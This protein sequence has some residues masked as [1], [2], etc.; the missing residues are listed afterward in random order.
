[1][2]A[3]FL[4]TPYPFDRVTLG[5]YLY[6]MVTKGDTRIVEAMLQ[7]GADPNITGESE[8]GVSLLRRAATNGHTDITG[9]LLAHG[10]NHRRSGLD[11]ISPL[12][13]A[14]A[15]GHTEIVTQLLAAGANPNQCD[16][17]G[18]HPLLWAASG[19]RAGTGPCVELLLAAGADP[20]H[21]DLAGY[22][23]L[24]AA[25]ETDSADRMQDALRQAKAQALLRAGADAGLKDDNGK[26]ARDFA[27]PP[28]QRLLDDFVTPQPRHGK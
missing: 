25:V 12:A 28:F 17:D 5:G 1:M 24:M 21:Q 8:L 11:G 14:A 16:R 4:L 2:S 3:R 7:A 19:A 26:T 15:N 6:V 22:T 23:S 20:N 27:E 10:A 13:A 9:M 18:W